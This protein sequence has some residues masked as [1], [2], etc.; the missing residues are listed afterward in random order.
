MY[1]KDIIGLDEI[2]KHLIACARRQD[3]PHA[4][5][6][7]SGDGTGA[8]ALALAYARYI[9]C[10]NPSEEDACGCCSSCLK[11]DQLA[12]QD[13][14]FLY[15]IVNG[16][17]NICDDLLPDWRKMLL[18]KNNAERNVYF[19]HKDWLEQIGAGNSQ[20]IIYSRESDVLDEKLAYKIAEAKYRVVFIWQPERM[21]EALAN[22]LLKLIE[23]PPTNTIILMVSH[24]PGKILGTIKSRAQQTNIRPL[25]EQEIAQGLKR[26]GLLTD[27]NNLRQVAHLAQGN[28]RE[29]LDIQEGNYQ[30]EQELEYLRDILHCSISASPLEMKKTTEKISSLG[31]EAQVA[32]LEY[33]I[34]FFRE[35]YIYNLQMPQLNYLHNQEI[36]DAEKLRGC[37]NSG[38]IR[39][40]LSETDLAIRHIKQNTNSKMVFFDFLLNITAATAQ[41]YKSKGL[42]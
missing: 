42:R 21:H 7:T 10:L 18:G 15:P 41:A 39:Q 28:F 5:L 22:K 25:T 11:Y 35:C 34:G 24:E 8:V 1:F 33:L 31:R 14:I 19:T 9:N 30:K 2:K 26:Y 32:L 29:A 4:Q 16:S 36:N 12:H 37:I 3:I 38:N 13:L 17:K 23:E 20:P 27:D 6:F 40:L